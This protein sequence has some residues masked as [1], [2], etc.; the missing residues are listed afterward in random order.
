MKK[1]SDNT[2]KRVNFWLEEEIKDKMEEAC[3]KKGITQTTA[4][5]MFAYYVAR[6]GKIPSDILQS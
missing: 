5:T 2:K 6:T 3:Q 4:Y 1:E